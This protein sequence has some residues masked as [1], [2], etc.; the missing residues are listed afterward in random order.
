MVDVCLLNHAGILL[1]KQTEK[2]KIELAFNI[3]LCKTA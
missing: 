3:V 2:C 1:I